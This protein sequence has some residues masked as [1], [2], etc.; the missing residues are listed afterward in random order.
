MLHTFRTLEQQMN[1][2][3][4]FRSNF[5]S[6]FLKNIMDYSDAVEKQI[7]GLFVFSSIFIQ[8]RRRRSTSR[9]CSLKNY[10]IKKYC[11]HLMLHC[12][13]QFHYID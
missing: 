9:N 8:A 3:I 6:I 13:T 7:N 12:Q 5:L 1:A 2:F 11:T 10:I 4:D